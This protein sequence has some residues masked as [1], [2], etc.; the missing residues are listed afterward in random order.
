MKCVGNTKY[1]NNV[2]DL[3][4]QCTDLEDKNKQ[5]KADMDVLNCNN[6][7]LVNVVKELK[8]QMNTILTC[9]AAPSALTP[10]QPALP[11]VS[12]AS[13]PKIADPPKFKGKANEQE[14]TACI[15]KVNE[16]DF[17]LWM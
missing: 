13:H 1:L 3:Q 2:G 8:V 11:T 15:V 16:Q 14:T 17:L 9:P 5:L 4:S 6:S 10:V 7:L 12:S